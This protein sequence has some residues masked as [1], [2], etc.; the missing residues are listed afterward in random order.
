[1]RLR[2][3]SWWAAWP[4]CLGLLLPTAPARAQA[5]LPSVAR[6]EV[7]QYVPVVADVALRQSGS[8][9]GVVVDAQGLPMPGTEVSVLQSGKVITRTRTDSLGQFSTVPLRGGVYQIA[10]GQG[11]TTLR[12]WEAKAA[13]P[14]ARPVALVV[15]SPEVVRGQRPFRS[16][17][18][19][20]AFVLAAVIAAA[21]A[22]PV[23]VSSAR[24]PKKSS[25]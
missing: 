11:A 1:M 19:S 22:I 20:D 8:L 13:P 7:P 3:C 23:A 10:A 14:A 5:P 17:I 21:I 15:G 16:L 18:F 12:A 9:L 25:S 6:P 2:H 4:A 24:N